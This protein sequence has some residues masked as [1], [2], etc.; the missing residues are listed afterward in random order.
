MLLD[1]SLTLRCCFCCRELSL[2]AP[3]LPNG[4]SP[5]TWRLQVAKWQEQ[6]ELWSPTEPGLIHSL[7]GQSWTPYLAS[8]GLSCLVYKGLA[9]Q[10]GE[11][12]GTPLQYSCLENP[13]DRGAWCAAVHGV[14]RSQ[15]R[16]SDFIFTFHFHALEKKMATHSSV[17]AW[18][19]PG[20]AEPGGLPS[21][22]LH[23]AG[24]DWSDL[25]AAA[26]QWR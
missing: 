16:L 19:I 6:H 5:D 13:M 10:W 22:G 2:P 11:G 24:H 4:I 12:N 18:R 26:W 20:T 23:R 1:A 17:L 25:A 15:T 14:A 7:A 3:Y 9:W 8:Q 21:V